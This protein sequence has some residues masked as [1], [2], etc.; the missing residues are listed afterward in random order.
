VSRIDLD[1]QDRGTV[2]RAR[3]VLAASEDLDTGTATVTDLLMAIGRLQATVDS[4][5][6]VIDGGEQRG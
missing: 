4:L 2:D 3:Q 1:A 6:R 5:L